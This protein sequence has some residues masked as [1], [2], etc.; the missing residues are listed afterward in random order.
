L[1]APKGGIFYSPTFGNH[2]FADRLNGRFVSHTSAAHR[3]EIRRRVIPH[4]RHLGTRKGAAMGHQINP[5]VAH[6]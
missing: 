2:I 1:S 3:P 6:S 4:I 5:V